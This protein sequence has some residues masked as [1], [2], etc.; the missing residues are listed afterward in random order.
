MYT[1]LSACAN[2]Y[3]DG[4]WWTNELPGGS[5]S[6]DVWI[7]VNADETGAGFIAPNGAVGFKPSTATSCSS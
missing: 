1:L 5:G 2:D 4:R 6:L 3:I 7:S